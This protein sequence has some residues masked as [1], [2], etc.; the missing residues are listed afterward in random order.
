MTNNRPV[1]L[2]LP[3]LVASNEL[4]RPEAGLVREATS[5]ESSNPELIES[6]IRFLAQHFP[7]GKYCDNRYLTTLAIMQD[8]QRPLLVKLLEYSKQTGRSLTFYNDQ[9]RR[10]ALTELNLTQVYSELR[11]DRC[12]R[13][14]LLSPLEKFQ[15]THFNKNVDIQRDNRVL[16]EFWRRQGQFLHTENLN[17]YARKVSADYAQQRGFLVE[18]A[19]VF[20]FNELHPHSIDSKID[21]PVDIVY[22][23]VN[24]ADPHWQSLFE[25]ATGQAWVQSTLKDRFLSRKELLYSLRSVELYAPWVRNVCVVTNCKPPEWIDV[26][27]PKLR[28][29]D[30]KEIFDPT[31]LP[32]F[33]SHAIE[34]RLHHVPDLA[35]HFLYFN[36][37]FFLTRPQWPDQYFRSNGVSCSFMEGYG[38]VNGNSLDQSFEYFN[39]ARNGKALL[40]GRF[41]VSVTQLHQHTPYALKKSILCE[42]EQVFSKELAVTAANK[43]RS[44]N[45]ISLPSFLYHHYAYLTRH[46]VRARSVTSRLIKYTNP[47]Y[48]A[49]LHKISRDQDVDVICINDGAGST[50]SLDWNSTVDAFLS[51]YF[52]EK[53]AFEN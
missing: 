52:G 4:V 9:G 22:T 24:H 48:T 12:W 53:S 36:D 31:C 3:D 13:L 41:G 15:A 2:P 16:F 7:I 26:R 49:R 32:T 23:W 14:R 6:L 38:V 8:S 28:W 43:F 20:D 11:R 35:E 27:H 33:N 25:T 34:S 19:P 51:T 30:H 37:D 44:V 47:D 17:L 18:R 50:E 1:S 10:F 40:E 21:F 29:I 46:A 5:A 39:A 45:D 42:I